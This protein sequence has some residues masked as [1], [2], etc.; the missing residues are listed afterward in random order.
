MQIMAKQN[1][2]V[3]IFDDYTG[4]EH[5]VKELQEAGPET[6]SPSAPVQEHT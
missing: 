3:A 1:S 2:T 4:A 5:A 6:E